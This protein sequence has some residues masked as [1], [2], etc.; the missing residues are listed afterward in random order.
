MSDWSERGIKRRDFRNTKGDPEV[1]KH[2]PK[3]KGKKP[4]RV[5]CTGFTMFGSPDREL[6]LGKYKK[7]EDAQNALKQF[8]A[9]YW[10]K[11]KLRIKKD[12]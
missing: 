6:T 1:P 4:Y 7:L 3:K 8:K 5:L 9:G 12:D 2:R 11:Y 10:G